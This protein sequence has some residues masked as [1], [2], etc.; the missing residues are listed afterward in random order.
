[1]MLFWTNFAKNGF[2]GTSSNGV[3]WL[4]Y[5]NL[6]S[7]SDFMVLD[8]RSNLQMQSDNFILVIG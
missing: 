4:K 1:M 8:K 5:T 3:K 2:R 6:S 7:Q